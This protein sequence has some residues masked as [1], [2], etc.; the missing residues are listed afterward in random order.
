[1]L[2]KHVCVGEKCRD[3]SSRVCV[4][5][6][7]WPQHCVWFYSIWIFQKDDSHFP[8]GQLCGD[9]GPEWKS[10]ICNFSSTV[11][12][13]GK[14]LLAVWLCTWPVNTQLRVNLSRT[15]DDLGNREKSQVTVT[16]WQNRGAQLCHGLKTSL[17][18]YLYF[19][20]ELYQ[21]QVKASWGKKKN[22]LFGFAVAA[23]SKV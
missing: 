8:L 6:R 9:R 11:H 17:S 12:L 3:L 7:G 22:H 5:K 15:E 23:F 1:M 21:K 16:V 18:H 2:T 20:R 19:I 10:L 13:E 14:H 4:L